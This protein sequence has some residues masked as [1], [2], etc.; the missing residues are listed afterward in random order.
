MFESEN[1]TTRAHEDNN[2]GP[3]TK[4]KTLQA[5]EEKSNVILKDFS[6]SKR[7]IPDS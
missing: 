5:I 7:L 3:K 4:D 2:K 6:I 1:G